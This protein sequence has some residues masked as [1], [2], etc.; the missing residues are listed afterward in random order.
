MTV[1]LN[2]VVYLSAFDF[3]TWRQLQQLVIYQTVELDTAFVANEVEELR[4]LALEHEVREA[5]EEV[6]DCDV[7]MGVLSG[8]ARC[9]ELDEFAEEV[10][11]EH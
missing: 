2:V 11:G 4:V 10:N 5:D 9:E 7:D 6:C 8:S 3:A 1:V